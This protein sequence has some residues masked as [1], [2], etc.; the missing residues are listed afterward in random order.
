MNRARLFS[1]WSAGLLTGVLLTCGSPAGHAQPAHDPPSATPARDGGGDF[2]FEIGTWASHGK[3]LVHPLTGSTTW[4]EFDGVTTVR[5]V[6]NSH[7]NLV[8]LIAD[9][10]QAGHIENLSLRLYDPE[11]HEWSLYYASSH[12]ADLSVPAVG[13]FKDGRGEFFDTETINGKS[14]KVRNLWTIASP[15]SCHFEQAFSTD[16]GTTWETNWMVTDTRVHDGPD[17]TH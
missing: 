12:G 1:R 9:G 17:H 13:H 7:A 5:K 14:I 6:W 4:I 16:N 10:P 2:D 8:E 11:S 15:D 3:R